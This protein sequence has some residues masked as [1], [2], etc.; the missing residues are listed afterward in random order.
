MPAENYKKWTVV[1]V[2]VIAAAVVLFAVITS[3]RKTETTSVGGSQQSPTPTGPLTDF[4]TQPPMQPDKLSEDPKQLAMLGDQYF[5]NGRY[6]L[7]VQMYEKALQKA[8]NDV[9]TYND[10]GLA[11]H[12]LGRPD[13]AVNALMKGTQVTP[14][15]QRVWLSL[16]FVLMSTGKNDEAKTALKKAAELN[17]GS[18]MGQ[19][20]QR[21][22]GSL[23]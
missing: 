19:E 22:L 7:A 10:M 13:A 12:Y 17:P 20:A 4:A 9:D 6:D 3:E 2:L 21:M 11:L 16:G 8:P 15:Y 18:D 23:K 5:E 14:S 1:A